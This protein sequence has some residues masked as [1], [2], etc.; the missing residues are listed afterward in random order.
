MDRFIGTVYLSEEQF[1]ELKKNGTITVNGQTVVYDENTIYMTP[2]VEEVKA[3]GKLYK[4]L[5]Q[6]VGEEPDSYNYQITIYSRKSTAYTF[7]DLIA[8]DDAA[9]NSLFAGNIMCST[10]STGGVYYIDYVHNGA[11]VLIL[12]YFKASSE[13]APQQLYAVGLVK[14]TFYEV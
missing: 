1:A 2:E 9:L 13:E 7:S 14:D 12:S 3:S 11:T 10:V 6:L 4:H 8:M 5:L